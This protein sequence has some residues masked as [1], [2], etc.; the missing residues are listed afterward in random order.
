[1]RALWIMG[2]LSLVPAVA[3]A[4]VGV[5]ATLGTTGLNAGVHV[6]VLPK[7]TLRGGISY[8]GYETGDDAEIEDIEYTID[9]DFTQ[10]GLYA[11]FHP[12]NNGFTII[13]GYV[14]GERSIDLS[15][16][17]SEDEDVEIGDELFTS[18]EI[19][20]LTGSGSLGDGGVFVGMGYDNTTRLT[21]PFQFIVRVGVIMGDDPFVTLQSEGG[22]LSDSSDLLEELEREVQEIN[23]DIEG[24][25]YFPVLQV[26]MGIPF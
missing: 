10:V 9:F 17:L 19:G 2:L 4:R 23:E 26:G 25:G 24:F 16:T 13:G 15:A 18:E 6:D 11:D 8:F 1:M 5:D 12:F 22:T 14:F 20:T 21:G 7:L 3:D